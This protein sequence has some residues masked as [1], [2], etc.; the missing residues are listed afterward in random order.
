MVDI[1]RR[2]LKVLHLPGHSEDSIALLD[3]YRHQIF[4]G[5]FIYPDELIAF[6]PGASIQQYL[7]GTRHLIN[8]TSGEETLCG[9]HA[10][11]EHSSPFLKCKALAEL[12]VALEKIMQG[13]LE[14]ER[15]FLFRRYSINPY[16]SIITTG[17]IN[18]RGD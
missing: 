12:D 16:M 2:Q 4:T 15:E 1:S 13:N 11:S 6:G 3:I 7:R 5:D 14:W 10:C 9:A 18:G 8:E 17:S